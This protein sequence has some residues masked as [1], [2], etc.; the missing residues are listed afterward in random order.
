MGFSRVKKVAFLLMCY[1]INSK[2]KAEGNI[3]GAKEQETPRYLRPKTVEK[4]YGLHRKT[5]ANLRSAGRGPRYLKVGRNVFYRPQDIE[6]WFSK[7][8]IEVKTEGEER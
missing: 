4:L 2:T 3:M 6:K 5:L 8:G 1:Y 7:H